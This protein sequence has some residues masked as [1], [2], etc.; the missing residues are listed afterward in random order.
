MK[1]GGGQGPSGAA[2]RS[3]NKKTN[4]QIRDPILKSMDQG[5]VPQF[6]KVD[7]FVRCRSYELK[8]FT[9]I[10]RDKCYSKLAW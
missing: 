4:Y 10:L 7:D 8:H 2:N 6:I 3:S 5:D 9:G 1:K